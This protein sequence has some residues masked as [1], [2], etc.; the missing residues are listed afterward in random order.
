LAVTVFVICTPVN[1]LSLLKIGLVLFDGTPLKKGE[2]IIQ[3]VFFLW[4]A[5][6][7]WPIVYWIMK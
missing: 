5:Q 4:Q 3:P 2:I 7:V 6:S 1:L